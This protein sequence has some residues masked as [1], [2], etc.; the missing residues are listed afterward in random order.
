MSD[1]PDD[2]PTTK[3]TKA[4]KVPRKL[5]AYEQETEEKRAFGA[6]L[7]EARETAGM[8]L[9]DAATSLG[10]SQ[11][12]Q[13][14]LMENGKRPVTMAVM[15]KAAKLYGTTADFLCGLV[16]DSDRDPA[17]ALQRHIA[18]RLTGDLQ[19]LIE[20]FRRVS[21]DTVRELMPS[22]ADAQRLAASVIELNTVMALFKQRNPKFEDMRVGATL[23]AKVLVA[24]DNAARFMA[25]VERA[26]RLLSAKTMRQ[27]ERSALAAAGQLSMFVELEAQPH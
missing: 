19:R 9:T 16:E 21:V 3:P 2:T 17:A 7:R 11:P 22:T 20:H 5:S 8:N 1:K 10:Y 13:L 15:V 14:S 23:D 24:S 12:V 18:A 27:D 4:R 26:Q 6:R 25:Q